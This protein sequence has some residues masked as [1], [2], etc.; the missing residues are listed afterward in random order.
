MSFFAY[1]P[2]DVSTFGTQCS[3]YQKATKSFQSSLTVTQSCHLQSSLESRLSDCL[4]LDSRQASFGNA[5]R[6]RFHYITSESDIVTSR[7]ILKKV[8]KTGPII[9]VVEACYWTGCHDTV[10][11]NDTKSSL[12]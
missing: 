2:L 5:L 7:H 9:E 3:L 12:V 1:S 4:R 8:G 10:S 6:D 11:N